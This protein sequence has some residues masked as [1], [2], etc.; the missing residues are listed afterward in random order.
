M[1]NR[2]FKP[3]LT[4]ELELHRASACSLVHIMG[5]GF[6]S[7]IMCEWGTEP[8]GLTTIGRRPQRLDT[9]PFMTEKL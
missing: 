5:V 4:R 1:F 8:N 7:D 3:G 6:Y 2:G 9:L